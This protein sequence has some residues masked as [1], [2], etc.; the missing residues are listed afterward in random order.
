MST[1]T[2]KRPTK[3]P[4]AAD[5]SARV[6][7]LVPKPK[8][9]GALGCANHLRHLLAQAERGEITGIAVA[10]WTP[11]GCGGSSVAGVFQNDAP[12]AHFAV[13]KLRDATLYYEEG[14]Q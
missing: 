6:L 7:H 13:S 3:A 5:S 11:D 8:D 2:R 10:T 14:A 12:I 1:P 4:R 9:Y